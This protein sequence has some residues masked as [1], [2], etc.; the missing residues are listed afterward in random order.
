MRTIPPRK[1]NYTFEYH[2]HGQT[3]D[4]GYSTW[5]SHYPTN[6]TIEGWRPINELL[7]P[8]TDLT[9]LAIAP[10]G[11]RHYQPNDDPVFGASYQR[12]GFFLPDKYI[13]PIGCIDRHAICNPNNGKYTHLM[14]KRGAI[15]NATDG[16][17]GLNHAQFVA[18]QRL[19]LVLLESSSFRDAVWTRTQGFLQAQERVAGSAGLALPSNQWEIE[20]AALFDDT[21]VN[22]QYHV[23]EYVAGSS[24]PGNFETIKVWEN[25]DT[26]N[27]W[28]NTSDTD[29]YA[30][31]YEHMCYNQRTRE[32]RETLNFSVLGLSLLLG[33]GTYVIIISFIMEFLMA[34]I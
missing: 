33:L 20:M 17:L 12:D 26:V 10:N 25:M 18:I 30:R 1:T 6:N 22:L 32:A 21:L 27:L 19:R 34:R 5:V 8:S 29:K 13:S 23:M 31:E 2:T 7:V 28:D 3:M 16:Q 11:V 15:K 24:I 9:I 4:I 14:D